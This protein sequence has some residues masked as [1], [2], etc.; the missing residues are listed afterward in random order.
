MNRRFPPQRIVV[1]DRDRAR[2]ILDRVG[3]R[4][5]FLWAD[6][7][8]RDVNWIT[9]VIE[10]TEGGEKSGQRLRAGAKISLVSASA[11]EKILLTAK[12]SGNNRDAR[13]DVKEGHQQEDRPPIELNEVAVSAPLDEDQKG[14]ARPA[15]G[16]P[17]R[18]G[19]HHRETPHP[20]QRS[21]A[22]VPVA[23]SATLLSGPLSSLDP[24]DDPLGG[25]PVNPV[26]KSSEVLSIPLSAGTSSTP[27]NGAAAPQPDKLSPATSSPVKSRDFLSVAL[28]DSGDDG[29]LMVAGSPSEG[30]VMPTLSQEGIATFSMDDASEDEADLSG[31]EQVEMDLGDQ[32]KGPAYV[33]PSYD[34]L[35]SR[36]HQ[37]ILFLGYEG[38]NYF[39]MPVDKG[40]VTVLR[41]GQMR[42]NTLCE[43]A[44]RALWAENFS[45]MTS[46]K[47][48][49]IRWGDAVS[50]LL[51]ESHKVG[52][53]N[54]HRVA[55]V[56][57]WYS[58]GNIVYNFGQTLYT[59]QPDPVS[60]TRRK[61][62]AS[63]SEVSRVFVRSLARAV[64]SF[65]NVMPSGSADTEGL[66]D[67]CRSIRWQR[68]IESISLLS[69]FG[70]LCL[71]PICGIVRNK[72][73]LWLYGPDNSGKSWVVRNIA[74][75]VLGDFA[76]NAAVT[77]SVAGLRNY[78]Q[79][80][81]LPVIIDSVDLT[82]KDGA[83]RV[84]ELLDM[85]RQSA[86]D[87]S[88]D[89]I[90]FESV[91]GGG[92]SRGYSINAT[93]LF[94]SRTTDAGPSNDLSSAAR[95]CLAPAHGDTTFLERLAAPADA[96][97]TPEYSLR[98]VERMIHRSSSFEG[99]VSVF[100]ESL[101]QVGFGHGRT[102]IYAPLCAAAWL[103]LEEGLPLDSFTAN[104]W[105]MRRFG[106]LMQDTKALEALQ[107]PEWV[108]LCQQISTSIVKVQ[109]R[110]GTASDSLGNLV[111]T[112]SGIIDD[113]VADVSQ[114]DALRA[115]Q[116][117]GIRLIGRDGSPFDAGSG[118]VPASIAF[119]PAS[120]NLRTILAGTAW[121][122][123]YGDLLMQ[124][125]QSR[126]SEKVIR[127]GA[128]G[129]ARG[130]VMPLD[131]FISGFFSK[132]P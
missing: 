118:G 104:A 34:V 101:L 33:P 127:F 80:T 99:A 120:P 126:R 11:D 85:A 57:C 24:P 76:I 107:A 1:P 119:H 32:R 94:A 132:D 21:R 45:Y 89:S 63:A 50:F 95:A 37:K 15:S 7:F 14:S 70:W 72:P 51:S 102:K 78:M 55:G 97:L 27:Q 128:L 17:K 31:A 56:G 2:M 66:F 41:A 75:R 39:F 81:A 121:A 23:G 12:T 44:P 54:P 96:L 82:R 105:I 90:H 30:M 84:S 48:L 6:P 13:P 64:P 5:V 91:S 73:F 60:R 79:H 26:P 77:T 22:E 16:G 93:F 19:E 116:L 59:M 86:D 98:F 123:A 83:I 25:D 108:T 124:C 42:E 65:L 8:E 4:E 129:P 53:W 20:D 49:S 87:V 43:L 111:Q 74:M 125:D 38:E 114:K 113:G 18:L 58:D 103:F 62:L 92:A 115:I 52:V 40:Q 36:M 68:D 67:L 117:Y 71:S 112:A 29:E 100:T 131:C 69:Y 106:S 9:D 3:L 47:S 109:A 46:K 28:P 35:K 88:Q 61:D 110:N 10:Q 130:I 122:N